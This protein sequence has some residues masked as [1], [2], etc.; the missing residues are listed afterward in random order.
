MDR[1]AYLKWWNR[2]VIH[3]YLYETTGYETECLPVE[4]HLWRYRGDDLLPCYGRFEVNIRSGSSKQRIH[5]PGIW[6][7]YLPDLELAIQH[8]DLSDEIEKLGDRQR[9]AQADLKDDF[10]VALANALEIAFTVRNLSPARHKY[11]G[12]IRKIESLLKEWKK[13]GGTDDI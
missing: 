13:L 9:Q 10:D 11:E 6:G 4:P 8:E 2:Y 12:M 1:I 5:R 7:V 3:S